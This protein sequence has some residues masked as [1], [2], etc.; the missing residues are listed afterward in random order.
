MYDFLSKMKHLQNVVRNEQM[1][2]PM[3][4]GLSGPMFYNTAH[5]GGHHHGGAIIWKIEN[6][7]LK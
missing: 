2:L 7:I 3:M 5:M 4:H 1:D 6:K